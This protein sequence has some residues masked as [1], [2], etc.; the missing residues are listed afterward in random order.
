MGRKY[1]ETQCAKRKGSLRKAKTD[2]GKEKV[3]AS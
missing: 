1:L 3:T 2:R